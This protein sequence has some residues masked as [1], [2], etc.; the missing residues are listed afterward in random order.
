MINIQVA[1]KC[2]ILKPLERNQLERAAEL[3]NCSSDIHYATGVFGEVNLQELTKKIALIEASENEFIIGL[4]VNKP[5]DD[6]TCQSVLAGLISGE[7]QDSSLWIKLILVSP[8]YRNNGFGSMAVKALLSYFQ[9]FLKVR[10]AFLSVIREN[11]K[12]INF[13][14]SNGFSV[15]KS[16]RKNVFNDQYPDQIVIMHKKL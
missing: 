2:I 13:W 5:E 16:I 9:S 4:H 10:E 1:E 6:G 12:A 14:M 8:E 15:M 7:L 11:T 3:Y